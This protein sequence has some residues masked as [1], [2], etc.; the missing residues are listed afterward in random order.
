M[1]KLVSQKTPI[2]KVDAIRQ[3]IL[4]GACPFDYSYTSS[5]TIWATENAIHFLQFARLPANSVKEI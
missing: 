5:Y 2:E 3:T 4:V 1:L